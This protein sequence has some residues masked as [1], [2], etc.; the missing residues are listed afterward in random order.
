M[1]P[2]AAAVTGTPF[3]P[4]PAARSQGR[5]ATDYERVEAAIRFLAER[6]LEQP[7]LDEV[8]AH[9]GLSP[10]HAQRLFRRWAGIS[11]KRFLQVLTV[12]H[13]KELLASSQSVLETAFATGLSG[14]GRLHDH[15]VALEALTPG[16]HK[17]GG[18]GVE[19]AYGVHPSPFGDALIA[20]SPRGVCRLV[21]LDSSGTAV[22]REVAELVK[23]WPRAAIVHD[24]A[25]TAAAAAR[26]FSA[27]RPGEGL[28]AGEPIGLA[29]RGTNLQVQVWKALLRIPPG[30]VVSYGGLAHAIGRPRAARAVAGA[31][32]ANP[33]GYL[34]PCHRVL[35]ASGE[36][37]GY[38]WGEARKRAMLAWESAV[39]A[40]ATA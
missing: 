26:I 1:S 29:V 27:L 10:F 23:E 19:I 16:E 25:S 38:R 6:R 32:A 3:D 22:E 28:P 21:F 18:A 33:V 4:A 5:T 7:T 24:P 40:A 35:R 34:I 2:L 8:A 20:V 13:A 14:P 37:G 31:V 9:L 39:P 12:E 15:F 11:P 17:E 36:I 30:A